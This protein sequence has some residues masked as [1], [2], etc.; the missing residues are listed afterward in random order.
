M[1]AEPDLSQIPPSDIPDALQDGIGKLSTP[2]K[3]LLMGKSVPYLIQHRLGTENYVTVEDL[4]DRW[5]TAQRAKRAWLEA[6]RNGFTVASSGFAAMKLFQ[7]VRATK[8]DLD[9]FYDWFYGPE[10]GG[11]RPSPPEQTFLMAERNAWREVHE[12]MHGGVNLKEAL[13]K[14]QNNSLFW[15]REV[16]ERVISQQTKREIQERQGQEGLMGVPHPPTSV[17]E[18][19]KGPRRQRGQR[20]RE[21]T[22]FK[23]GFQE[24]EECSLLP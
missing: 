23:L 12:L 19:R 20:K 7:V 10:M 4:A 21:E 14:V 15:M 3:Q 22:K 13:E 2:L 9:S 6:N 11:R 17:G 18:E 8:E 24:S 1:A 16:Y 5:D